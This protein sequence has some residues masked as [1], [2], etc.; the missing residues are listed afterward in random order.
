MQTTK[1]TSRAQFTSAFR[2]IPDEAKSKTDPKGRVVMYS[3]IHGD[4]FYCFHRPRN[5]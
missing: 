1:V 5:T 4:F 2:E 3:N